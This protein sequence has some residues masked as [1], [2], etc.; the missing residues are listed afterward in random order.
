[1][2]FDPITMSV[3]A[4]ASTGLKVVGDLEQGQAQANAANYNAEVARNN[5][6]H[7]SEAGQAA[8]EN[9]SLKG[10]ATVG[11]L[12]ATAAAN[13]ITIGQPGR[14]SVTD[15]AR[16]A[17]MASV[18]NATNTENNALVTAYGYQ[19]QAG[20]DKAQA[21]QATTG[22]YLNAAGDALGGASKIGGLFGGSSGDATS[23]SSPLGQSL[24]SSAAPSW[25]G[26]DLV[27]NVG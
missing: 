9:E 13:N 4:I 10:A 20:L 3:L 23:T 17:R 26:S 18:V 6:V 12:K 27:P 15:V 2:G 11:R 21:S 22:S 24:Q 1:M 5:A 25:A 16:S 14:S 8:A 7:A 19:A